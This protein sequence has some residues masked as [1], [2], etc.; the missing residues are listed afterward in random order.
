MT[1]WKPSDLS[2]VTLEGWY[3]VHD[4]TGTDPDG[5]DVS[6]TA[7]VASWADKSGHGRTLTA[8]GTPLY[9]AN[10]LATGHPAVTAN[11]TGF[12]TAAG[13]AYPSS[14]VMGAMVLGSLT[15]GCRV[16]SLVASSGNDYDANGQIPILGGSSSVQYWYNFGTATSPSFTS[17]A[18][19]LMEGVPT[20]TTT[21]DAGINT[22]DSGAPLALA[23]VTLD[24][25]GFF[26]NAG[27]SADNPST[28]ATAAEFVLWA[29]VISTADLQKLQ[30]YIAWNNGQQALL[31]GGHPY[32]S[33]APTIS[34]GGGGG[35]VARKT[36]TLLG[37]G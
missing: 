29:G 37:V 31:P 32:A 21:A 20:S 15:S 30:G 25:M 26:A 8:I 36:F 2:S 23:G 9:D 12:R 35:P 24:R 10:G 13:M 34:G 16:V 6:T 11:G 7:T 18:V 28:L 19:V 4:V 1:L 17:G 33:A 14:A 27:T 22:V 3:R 5:A